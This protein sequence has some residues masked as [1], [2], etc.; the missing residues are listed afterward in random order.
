M[1]SFFR[2][3]LPRAAVRRSPG[4]PWALA[5]VLL[6]G[7]GEGLPTGQIEGDPDEDPDAVALPL[8]VTGTDPAEAEQGES[9][10]VRIFGE[11]FAEGSVASWERDG[12][13]DTLI[14][15]S[16]VTFVSETELVAS[17]SVARETD[18]GLYDVAVTRK[19]KKGVGSEAK[20]I[21]A[22]IFQVNEY[23]PSPLGWLVESI[24]AGAYSW[25]YTINDSGVAAG[26]AVDDAW[27][28]TAVYWTEADGAVTFG[29]E[30]A[31]ALGSN[32]RG[33]IVGARGVE[34][35]LIYATPF[36]FEDGLVTDLQPL[37]APHRSHARAINETGTIVGWGARD[38]WADPTWPLVWL[39]AD[40]G[41]Y[42]A[43][44]Q[45]PLP[46]GQVWE[47]ND[48]TEGSRA[49]AINDDGEIVG[50]LR[51]GGDLGDGAYLWRPGPDG[52]YQEP[53]RLGGTEAEARGINNGGWIVGTSGGAVLW[54]PNDYGTPIRLAGQEN[55]AEAVA[56]NDAGQIAGTRSTGGQF[57]AVLWTVDAE[58]NTTETIDLV[59]APGFTSSHASSINARGWVVGWSERYNPHRTVATLWRPE[60]DS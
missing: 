53:L 47:V 28:T 55:G 56:I 48:Y 59:P 8:E 33:W 58:G 37:E 40:D 5:L 29:G 32:D 41:S 46:D 52:T 38:Y 43:P 30:E 9:V 18:I 31:V 50:M 49:T 23:V 26:S 3:I 2:P 7:C 6:I 35:D 45:L 54:H 51:L 1:Q 12:V 42:G 4:S 19:R 16:S 14:V 60:D 57:H 10:D 11:G 25:A 20:A 21:G 17:I 22:D 44:A 36:I 39:R 24:W 13:A 27:N 15:V 34:N